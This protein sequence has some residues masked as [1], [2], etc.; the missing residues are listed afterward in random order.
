MLTEAQDTRRHTLLRL[1]PT[2]KHDIQYVEGVSAETLATLVEEGFANPDMTQNSSPSIG[3]FLSYMKAHPKVTA[4][5]YI[6]SRGRSDARVSIEGLHSNADDAE[7]QIEFLEWNR[8][9]DELN[10]FRSWWD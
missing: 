6:V 5:G 1:N 7:E 2:Q 3:Q 10:R 4:H 9:A 8:G